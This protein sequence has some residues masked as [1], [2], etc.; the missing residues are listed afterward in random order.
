MVHTFSV[1]TPRRSASYTAPSDARCHYRSICLH[2]GSLTTAGSSVLSLRSGARWQ[3]G[4]ACGVCARE[5]IEYDRRERVRV[6]ASTKHQ[7][8]YEYSAAFISQL[9]TRSHMHLW[10][11]DPRHT[12]ASFPGSV[13]DCREVLPSIN[14]STRSR[15]LRR[16]LAIG[17]ARETPYLRLAKS[18]LT[19]VVLRRG[20]TT[21]VRSGLSRSSTLRD[22]SPIRTRRLSRRRSRSSS[23]R[24]VAAMRTN[25]TRLY[26]VNRPS[27]R[28]GPGL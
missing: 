7:L 11:F 28:R 4:K 16:T 27:D 14:V 13:T 10:S 6:D 26:N 15:I 1:V 5:R 19:L 9:L 25:A 2:S 12:H 20:R 21:S 18:T 23:N 3:P 22:E 24:V 17:I 8:W